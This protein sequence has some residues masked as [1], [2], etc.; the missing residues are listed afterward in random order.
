[1]GGQWG[2]GAGGVRKLALTSQD[3]CARVLDGG[4]ARLHAGRETVPDLLGKIPKLE[5]GG[6]IAECIAV[7]GAVSAG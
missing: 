6:I 3:S 5:V 1:M 4:Q 2:A 7:L